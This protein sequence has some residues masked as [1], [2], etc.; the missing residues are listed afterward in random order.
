MPNFYT[1]LS[2][3]SQKNQ[4]LLCVGLDPDPNHMAIKDISDFNK[5]IIDATSD[6]VCCYKP[7]LAF[8][9]SM[10]IDGLRALETTLNHIPEYIPV[11]GDAKRGDV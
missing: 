4:S 6:L 2:Q 8:Y 1:K 9:E 10:G 5:R 3:A 11:I 7:N